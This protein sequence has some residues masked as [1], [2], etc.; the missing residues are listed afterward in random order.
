MLQEKHYGGFSIRLSLKMGRNKWKDK[1]RERML[2]MGRNKWKDKRRERMLSWQSGEY[3]DE[4][5]NRW[6]NADMVWAYNYGLKH[7]LVKK[8]I[9]PKE[10]KRPKATKAYR[11]A[12]AALKELRRYSP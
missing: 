4:C 3:A 10:I 12:K 8:Y 7:G 5:H 9:L 2:K 1:R 11:K 6:T